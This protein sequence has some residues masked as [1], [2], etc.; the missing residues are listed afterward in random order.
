MKF[1]HDFAKI[2]FLYTN[3]KIYKTKRNVQWWVNETN[4]SKTQ[5]SK[6]NFF[7]YGTFEKSKD[8]DMIT[9]ASYSIDTNKLIA[10]K[11]V[12]ADGTIIIKRFNHEHSID[13]G[14]WTFDKKKKY[15]G[16]IVYHAY[17]V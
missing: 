16:D 3:G 17:C 8:G 5:N 14:I 4:Y 9:N 1:T 12:E 13:I 6:H 10:V 11:I 15:N 7:E 2:T